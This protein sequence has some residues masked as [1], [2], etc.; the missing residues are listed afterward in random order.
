M[1]KIASEVAEGAT[2]EVQAMKEE[3]NEAQLDEAHNKIAGQTHEL[4]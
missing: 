4:N 1:F 2:K 3:I